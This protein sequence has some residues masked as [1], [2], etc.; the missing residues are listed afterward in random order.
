MLRTTTQTSDSNGSTGITRWM[1][2]PAL[3]ASATS[4]RLVSRGLRFTFN[5]SMRRTARWKLL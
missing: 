4:S 5:P 3:A 1:R 2:S